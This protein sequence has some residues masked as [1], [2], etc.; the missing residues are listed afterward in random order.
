MYRHNNNYAVMPLSHEVPYKGKLFHHTVY[1]NN[2]KVHNITSVLFCLI[3]CKYF[4]LMYSSLVSVGS[5]PLGLNSTLQGTAI[6]LHGSKLQ[7]GTTD[8]SCHPL[9]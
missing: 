6:S 1:Q 9:Y 3:D 5:S 4:I 7:L 8:L 2:V